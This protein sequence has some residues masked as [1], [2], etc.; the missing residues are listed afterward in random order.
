MSKQ[1]VFPCLLTALFLAGCQKET[2]D[3]AASA[4]NEPS[5]T[6]V[7]TAQNQVVDFLKTNQWVSKVNLALAERANPNTK[8]LSKTILSDQYRQLAENEDFNFYRDLVQQAINPKAYQCSPTALSTYIPP[9]I[10][11][12]SS[13]DLVFYSEFGDIPF[14]EAYLYDNTEGDDDYFGA[15]G[16]FSH[17][18]TSSF[19]RLKRF[20]NIPTNIQVTDAHGAI[21][22]NVALVT[23]II[24]ETYMRRDAAGQLIP[25]DY[26]EA[27]AVAKSLKTIFG[28]KNFLHYKHPLFSFNAFAANSFP[29]L[30]IPKKIVM[31]DGLLKAFADLGYGAVAPQEILAHEYGHHIQLANHYFEKVRSPEATRRTELMAD[32]FSAYFLAHEQG[33][34]LDEPQIMQVA[35]VAFLTG[36]CGFK[37]L[38]H[39]G[40]PNQRK[41]AS[42]WGAKLATNA[43]NDDEK[44]TSQA[45]DALFEAALPTILLPD[46]L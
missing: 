24:Q 21:Y 44:L 25:V 16:E 17:A 19:R 3:H 15:Q 28:S 43:Q 20:W 6:S 38:G 37:S 40:T 41:K 36:D 8:K 23:Q 33:A 35:A 27:V 42:L 45:F 26:E 4:G 30:G 46:A 18:V 29:A 7:I 10:K 13:L 31:G 2:V 22:K 14:L 32:A 5:E 12:W 1:I 39:H 11:N 34:E 9:L